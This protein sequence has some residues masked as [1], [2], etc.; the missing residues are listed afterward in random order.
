MVKLVVTHIFHFYRGLRLC[1]YGFSV[2]PIAAFSYGHRH[3]NRLRF[4]LALPRLPPET[5][6]VGNDKPLGAGQGELSI[7]EAEGDVRSPLS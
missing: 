1:Q 2:S 5:K 3:S 7:Q 4:H 6:L